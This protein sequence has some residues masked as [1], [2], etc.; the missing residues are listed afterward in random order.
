VCEIVYDTEFVKHNTTR[1]EVQ[2][3]QSGFSSR[4]CV[5]FVTKTLSNLYRGAFDK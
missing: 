4:E 5:S 2:E 1:E 3:E